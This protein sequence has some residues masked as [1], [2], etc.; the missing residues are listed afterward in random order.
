[1]CIQTFPFYYFL[2]H[3]YCCFNSFSVALS[4]FCAAC[5]L[6]NNTLFLYRKI[7]PTVDAF[8]KSGTPTS[9]Y[10]KI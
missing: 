5:N 4:D 8:I 1:M 2:F 6:N 10:S 3:T 7:N 9:N